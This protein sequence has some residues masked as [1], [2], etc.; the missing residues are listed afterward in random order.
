MIGPFLTNME[1]IIRVSGHMHYTGSLEDHVSPPSASLSEFIR[2]EWGRLRPLV[3]SYSAVFTKHRDCVIIPYST[4]NKQALYL[5]LQ[6][7][8]PARIEFFDFDNPPSDVEYVEAPTLSD[9]VHS[10]A[11]SV[12]DWAKAG[13]QLAPDAVHAERQAT[14]GA[15]EHWKPTAFLGTGSCTKCG[16]SGVKLKL[17]TSK[18]PIG[19]WDAVNNS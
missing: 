12:F 16:C 2:L 18:C 13:F 8:D 6:T 9:K 17:A 3:C 7:P 5:S 11:K 14:C 15:C 10:L 19:K 4:Q 1:V